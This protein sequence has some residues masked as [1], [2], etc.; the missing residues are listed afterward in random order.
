MGAVYKY[1]G[2]VIVTETGVPGSGPLRVGAGPTLGDAID[3][4]DVTP[5]GA[6][7][8]ET[9]AIRW[10]YR[11]TP[12]H[13]LDEEDLEV[14]ELADSDLAELTTEQREWAHAHLDCE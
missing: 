12:D 10:A 5:F 7:E 8:S 2:D 11:E 13:D 1:H 6:H 9:R 3:A 4:L 14:Y